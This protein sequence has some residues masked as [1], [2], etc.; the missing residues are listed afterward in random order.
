MQIFAHNL[1]ATAKYVGAR[2][3]SASRASISA[4]ACS[5]GA[6]WG[7]LGHSRSHCVCGCPPTGNLLYMHFNLRP[8]NVLPCTIIQSEVDLDYLPF[9]MGFHLKLNDRS[10]PATKCIWRSFTWFSTHIHL[11]IFFWHWATYKSKSVQ[12]WQL[13]WQPEIEDHYVANFFT[14][15]KAEI[16]VSY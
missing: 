9:A 1:S 12:I 3:L 11:Y 4:A 2:Q 7:G 5:E 14:Y 10:K 13:H 15:L 16:N 8:R 6:G